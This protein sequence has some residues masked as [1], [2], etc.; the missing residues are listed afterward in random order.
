V[1]SVLGKNSVNINAIAQGAS[2][3]SISFV[4]SMNKVNK[5][6]RVLH[7]S[8]FLGGEL[9][10]D[11]YLAGIGSVGSALIKQ[12]D[13]QKEY[14][15]KEY[16]VDI[17]VK[18]LINSS[19]M[20]VSDECLIN[21]FNKGWK[22][23][24]SNSELREFID[25]ALNSEANNKI[26]VDCTA[27]KEIAE[28]YVDLLSSGISVVTANKIAASG[29]Y[30]Y[31]QKLISMGRSNGCS[32]R[33]ETNVG[34]GLPVLQTIED[35]VK[36]GDRIYNIDAVLSGSLNYIFN[37]L[38]EG[39]GLYEAIKGAKELGFTEP[40]PRIDLSGLDVKR[41]L[42]ILSRVAGYKLEASQVREKMFLPMNIFE[43]VDIEQFWEEVKLFEKEFEE[44]L[45]K[46]FIDGKR[47]RY[48]ASFKEGKAEIGLMEVDS[49]H[50]FFDLDDSNNIV[51][52]KS[53]RYKK[54]PL[55]IKGYGAGAEVTAAGVFADIMKSVIEN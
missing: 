29:D 15:K 11:V 1:F 20:L 3:S 17:S 18:G 36:S 51:M 12:I 14:I 54:Q 30:D 40:D 13:S 39:M 47:L 31:Y 52:I 26:F 27:S 50:P 28:V 34:A 33:N 32:F 7:D 10:L 25:I 38:G 44:R 5:V 19:K 43:T 45:N 2:E 24:A 41:K 53:E 21:R 35:M 46:I 49:S 37:K 55:I 23:E 9:K 4:I 16:K 22:N 8:F 48:V 42:L 6:I